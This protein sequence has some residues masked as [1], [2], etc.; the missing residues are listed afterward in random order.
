MKPHEK[1]RNM[2]RF[3]ILFLIYISQYSFPYAIHA[4]PTIKVGIYNNEPL[5]FVDKDGKGRGI[6][7]DILEHIASKEGWQIEYV[8]GT[9]QQGLSR[10]EN[11]GIDI[12]CTI[13]FSRARDTRYDF[14][15]ENLLTNWGQL[16]TQIGSD[17]KA[18][19]D[20]AGKKVAV[21]KGD[22]H[23]ANFTQ[24]IERFGIGCEII[25]TDDY[26]AVLDLVANNQA[27]AGIINRFF[28]LKYGTQYKVDQ[29][30]VIFNPI[31]I[32]Y[33]VPKGK[34]K[35]LIATLDRYIAEL[36]ENQNSE[37]YRSLG[38]WFEAVPPRGVFPLWSKWAIAVT[39]GIAIFLFLGT[40][41]LRNRVR[42]KT[43][44]LTI[45]LNR[46]KQTENALR[47]AYSIIN[48]SPAVAFL[49]KNLEG[50]PVEFV[51]DN[52]MELFGYTAEEFT[53]G[54]VSYAKTVHPD[55]LERVAK[56]V[57]TFSNETLPNYFKRWKSEMG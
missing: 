36:K 32:H 18:I 22:I 14:T 28:G 57:A 6:F 49:W 29:S 38:Q 2:K 44:E 56:E 10:L 1:V 31:K 21:L 19:T 26:H 45:E 23:Y 37:Y 12:L 39:L 46:R 54:Q 27:D 35:E 15:S 33:A 53:S 5:I 20:V 41:V 52:V 9:W 43:K 51:S 25:E 47:E 17:I 13:A 34:N 42:A 30:G 8:A 11:N 7:A 24:I 40:L 16:Y 55:D 4:M 48:R 3:L 50:W